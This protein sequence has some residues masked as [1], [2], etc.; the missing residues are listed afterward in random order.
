MHCRCHKLQTVWQLRYIRLHT[1]RPKLQADI[2]HFLY[3]LLERLTI[4]TRGF[5][6]SYIM[7]TSMHWPSKGQCIELT[8]M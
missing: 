2:G 7:V 5:Y 6:M 4:V 3:I 1:Q 8:M